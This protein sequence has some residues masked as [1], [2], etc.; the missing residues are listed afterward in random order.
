MRGIL[1]IG[2][3]W[4]FYKFN[5]VP[6]L[7]HFIHEQYIGHLRDQSGTIARVDIGYQWGPITFFKGNIVE[8]WIDFCSKKPKYNNDP[9]LVGFLSKRITG[10]INPTSVPS[11]EFCTPR[12]QCLFCSGHLEPPI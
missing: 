3:P 12:G 9:R 10:S 11:C 5:T 7:R 8:A 4:N 1:C 2:T 6:Q